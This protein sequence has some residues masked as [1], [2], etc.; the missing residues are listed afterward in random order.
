MSCFSRSM[1]SCFQ[2]GRVRSCTYSL[3]M[4]DKSLVDVESF[5]SEICITK[6]NE[7]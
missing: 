7:V 4:I 1:Q 3:L 6:I 5:I 2:F